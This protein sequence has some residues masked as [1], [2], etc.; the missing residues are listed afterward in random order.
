MIPSPE[1]L[2]A[3]DDLEML[4]LISEHGPEDVTP[5]QGFSLMYRVMRILAKA[6]LGR[7]FRAPLQEAQRHQR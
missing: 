4:Q 1:E 5:G 3:L 7:I 6:H 2:D